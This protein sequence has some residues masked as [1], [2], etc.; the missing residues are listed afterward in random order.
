MELFS[1][2]IGVVLRISLVFMF[3]WGLIGQYVYREAKKEQRSSPTHRGL[4]WGVFG[5]VGAI[6]YL[7]RIRERKK[8]RLAWLGFSILL[9]AFWAIAT[10]GQGELDRAFRAWAAAFTGLL[11][12]YWQFNLETVEDSSRDPDAV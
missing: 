7:T 2:S 4:F 11:I 3:F 9:F 6:I 1:L 12:L 5:V 10:I 8:N